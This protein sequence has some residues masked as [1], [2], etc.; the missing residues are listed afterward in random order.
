MLALLA[1]PASHAQ[2]NTFLVTDAG[3]GRLNAET[4]YAAK[5]VSAA[6]GGMTVAE[7]KI[8]YEDIPIPVLEATRDGKRMLLAFRREGGLHISRAITYAPE[9]VTST[10]V[11][12][13]MP[14]AKVFHRLPDRRC[15]NGLEQEKGRVF[16]PAPDFENV[17]LMFRCDYAIRNDS[18]PPADVLAR[19]PVEGIIWISNE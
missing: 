6:L 9:S 11:S 4:T 16:C 13:G 5:D 18:L 10:G 7:S 12:V 15:R 19:C 1:A 8:Y 14:M 2:N 3:I 17:R